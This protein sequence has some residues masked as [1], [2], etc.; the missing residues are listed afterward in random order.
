[1][2]VLEDVRFDYG[3]AAP[4]VLADL[5]L[6]IG[7][8]EFVCILGPSGCGKTTLLHLI[9]GF[10]LP[11]RGRVL[12]NGTA[13]AGPAPDR[14][15]V[16]QDAALFPWLTVR[17]NVAFGLRMQGLPAAQI[18]AT[19]EDLLHAMGLSS[20]ADKHPHALSGG[21]RQR[22]AIARVL[23]LKPRVLLMDEP[24][25]AL[26]ANSRERL[27]DEVLRLWQEYRMTV[28]YVTHSVDEAAY[29]ADRVFLMEDPPCGRYAEVHCGARRVRSRT[30]DNYRSI[31][32]N[33]RVE[34]G[35]LP[36]C[37]P[38]QPESLS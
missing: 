35:K 30:D 36:C 37:I 21:M 27:Q 16:F 18:H 4:P 9:A 15:V 34:L 2:I 6:T 19:A 28:V 25:S 29:L 31:Q 5:N 20:H 26:D 7:H 22:V 11:T 12:C 23:A 10:A 3:A 14:G 17:K 38:L 8:G 24:F 33:L 32:E 13:V 1:M